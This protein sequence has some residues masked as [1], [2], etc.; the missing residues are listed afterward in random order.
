MEEYG[1]IDR[2]GEKIDQQLGA[3]RTD[4]VLD[5]SAL[6]YDLA[7]LS[8]LARCRTRSFSEHGSKRH[9]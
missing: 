1:A 2:L 6:L 7:C 3:D 8:N 4:Q 5:P 9:R